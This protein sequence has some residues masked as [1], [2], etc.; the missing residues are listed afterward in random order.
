MQKVIL[1][2]GDSGSGKDFVLS[3]ANEY[4]SIQVVKRF[5]SRDPRNGEDNSISSV[6]SVPIDHIQSLEYSYEGVESGKWYGICK[7]DLDSAFQKGKSPIVVCPNYENYLQMSN[8]YSGNIVPI[9]IYRGYDDSELDQWRESLVARGS[10]SDEIEAREKKRDQYFRE[11]YIKHYCEYGSNVIL[12]LYGITT[13][14]D[15]RLQLE[16]LCEKN[17][18]DIDFVAKSKLSK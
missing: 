9:F 4:D 5:I 6:F 12:N 17:D 1:L 18:I 16:G 2:V 10:S 13:K 11:L 7:K 14:E 15:I 3:V 8:D